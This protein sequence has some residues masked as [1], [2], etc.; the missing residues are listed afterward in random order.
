MPRPG[1]IIALIQLR[2]DLLAGAIAQVI[3]EAGDFSLLEPAPAGAEMLD[4]LADDQSLKPLVVMVGQRPQ[5]EERAQTLAHAR[6][7]LVVVGIPIQEARSSVSIPNP[8][9]SR[10]IGLLRWLS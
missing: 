3:R 1:K 7:D 4:R 5:L 6:P 9:L 2:P 10:L 8:T